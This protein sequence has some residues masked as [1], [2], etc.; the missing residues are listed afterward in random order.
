[1][2]HRHYILLFLR[3]VG[4]DLP[5]IVHG[6]AA[7]AGSLSRAIDIELQPMG[8]LPVPQ[9]SRFFFFLQRPSEQVARETRH[10]MPRLELDP[11]RAAKAVSPSSGEGGVL[12]AICAMN[13]AAEG[14]MLS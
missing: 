6:K 8:S 2:L 1:M 9:R 5:R 14:R 10:A 3:R 13:G 7:Y 11:A 12:V 4:I